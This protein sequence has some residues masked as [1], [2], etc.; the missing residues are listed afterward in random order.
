MKE[1]EGKIEDNIEIEEDTVLRGM[2][3]GDVQVIGSAEFIL[4]G[5]VVGD[6]TLYENTNVYIRGTVSGD[7][8]NKGGSLEVYGVI[9]GKLIKEQGTNLID[10]DAIIER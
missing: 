6:I 2:I 1:I 9:D 5:M 4:S 8:I 7:V 10:K 3:V